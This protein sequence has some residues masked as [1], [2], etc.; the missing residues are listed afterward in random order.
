[1]TRGYAGVGLETTR[2]LSAAGEEIRAAVVRACEVSPLITAE[3]GTATSVWCAINSLRDGM[4][5]VY[6]ENVDI[7]RA[8]P[9]DLPELRGVR[10][11][12]TDPGFAERSWTMSEEWTGVAFSV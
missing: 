7:A 6:C 10:P 4:G 5:G 3:Q 1:V 11:W 12:A 8:V 9:A 2:A